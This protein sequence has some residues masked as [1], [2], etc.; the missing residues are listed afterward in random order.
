MEANSSKNSS[1]THRKLQHMLYNSPI[2]KFTVHRDSGPTQIGK[3]F[4]VALKQLQ[5]HVGWLATDVIGYS[6]NVMFLISTAWLKHARPTVATTPRIMHL[7]W[8]EKEN[9]IQSAIYWP[10]MKRSYYVEALM[11]LYIINNSRGLRYIY[12]AIYLVKN[13]VFF[14]VAS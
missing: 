9:R 2:N 1:S 6:L 10:L 8:E 14:M 12:H 3:N 4:R 5:K 7:N 11:S 13:Y